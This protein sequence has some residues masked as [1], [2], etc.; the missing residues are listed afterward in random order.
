MKVAARALAVWVLLSV[1]ETVHGLLRRAVLGAAADSMAARQ[2]GVVIG[3]VLILAVSWFTVRWIG[4]TSIR[5]LLL[6]GLSWVV[7]TVAFEIGLGRVVGYSWERIASDYD[8]RA[9][10]LMLPGLI[11]LGLAPLLAA[12]A[13]GRR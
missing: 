3:S 10:G 5:G 1:V 8:L 13:Q 2:L 9:G 6:I 12:L 11:V 4:S 7:F